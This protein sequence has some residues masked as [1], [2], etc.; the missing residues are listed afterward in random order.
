[1][2]KPLQALDEIQRFLALHDIQHVVIGG[3]ANAI[4]PSAVP[5]PV[6]SEEARLVTVQPK[7]SEV[8]L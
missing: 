7:T 4:N 6:A 3:I 5:I 2:D 8:V 1:M